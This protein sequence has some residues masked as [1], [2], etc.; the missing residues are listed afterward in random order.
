MVDTSIELWFQKLLSFYV[1]VLYR[2]DFYIEIDTVHLYSSKCITLPT[3]LCL[4][5]T[6]TFQKWLD[7]IT[8]TF[9]RKSTK[10][11]CSRSVLH[12]LVSIELWKQKTESW[13]ILTPNRRHC[14]WACGVFLLKLLW[15][16]ACILEFNIRQQGRIV[17][18]NNI[19]L[20]R[21]EF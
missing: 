16:L 21:V 13:L 20:V 14:T 18:L 1:L 5:Y 15:P 12:S 4:F 9:N 6:R 2:N 8:P 7:Q 19:K 11:P 17:D 3:L 10:Y